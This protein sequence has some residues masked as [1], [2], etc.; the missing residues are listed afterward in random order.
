MPIKI[1][2]AVQCGAWSAGWMPKN[3]TGISATA[4]ER[5]SCAKDTP[6]TLVW[7][8]SVQHV[9]VLSVYL[10]FPLVVMREAGA[11]MRDTMAVLALSLLAMAVATVVQSHRRLGS[12]LLC[13]VTFTAAYIGPSI[14][15]Y[16]QGGLPLVFGMTV[17]AG[18]AEM[19]ISPFLRRL[20]ALFPPEMS[21]LVVLLVGISIGSLA[22]RQLPGPLIDSVD[23]PLWVTLLV[24]F[25]TMAGLSVWGAPQLRH[26]AVLAGMMVG[27]VYAS[28]SGV[29][30]AAEFAAIES[31]PLLAIPRVGQWGITFD[32]TLIT[33]FVIAAIAASTKAAGILTLAQRAAVGNSPPDR[34]M[35]ARG[36]FADG[37]G[38]AVAGLFGTTGLSTSPS[39][40]ALVAATGITSRRVAA[41]IGAIF[42]IL[43]FLPPLSHALAEFPRP[44]IGATMF[45]T[46]CLVLTNGLQMIAAC[47]LDNRKSLVVG[48]SIIA[49]LAIEA[50][51]HI[52]EN[53]PAFLAPIMAS[54]LVLGTSVGIAFTL[55]FRI[56]A[57]QRHILAMPP[58]Q[59]AEMQSRLF[60]GPRVAAAKAEPATRELLESITAAG[61][62]GPVTLSMSFDEYAV[63]VR[64]AYIGV[65]PPLV[66]DGQHAARAFTRQH[67]LDRVRGWS[68]RDRV[69][70]DFRLSL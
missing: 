27:L 60:A 36:I 22:V 9:S 52:A 28:F 6:Q 35:I 53:A 51:P 68:R 14:L 69:C 61:L 1:P 29:F 50:H 25:V 43:A 19:A 65:L 41:A 57:K 10:T 26:V 23:Q 63:Y 24:T 54:S 18:C 62:S 32:P 67:G 66:T 3:R 15:A 47:P 40:V 11:S 17:F 56:G 70:V 4:P 45:F 8:S 21:G 58:A 37:L 64:A 13:P 59:I 33:P 12:G 46:G 7:L 48:L 34:S 30:S 20:R 31:E 5:D 39:S 16:R 49:A 38:T 55:L 42:S 44:V 2:D